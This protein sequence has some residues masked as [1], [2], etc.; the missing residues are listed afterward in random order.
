M[1]MI[2]RGRSSLRLFSSSPSP[3]SSSS[4][5]SFLFFCSLFLD[6]CVYA[7]YRFFFIFSILVSG[8]YLSLFSLFLFG[9]PVCYE[10]PNERE[11]IPNNI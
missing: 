7:V 3:F 2:L 1:E 6:M 5:F 4:P 11:E 8:L 10:R 9:Y